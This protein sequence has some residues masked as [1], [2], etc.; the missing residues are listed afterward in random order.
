MWLNTLNITDLA[1]K[2]RSKKGIEIIS[3]FPI[4]SDNMPCHSQQRM[5]ILLDPPLDVNILVKKKKNYYP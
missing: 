3:L 5:E 4:P 2:D 1:V